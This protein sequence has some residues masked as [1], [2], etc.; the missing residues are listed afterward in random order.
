[1]LRIRLGFN[2]DLDLALYVNADPDPEFDGQNKKI[3][4]YRG[5][6]TVPGT[7]S[8]IK[9]CNLRISLGLRKGHPSYKSSLQPSKANMKIPSL[10]LGFCA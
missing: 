3:K 6:N 10:I 7:I 4:N 9:S 1:M 2:A 5:K 8:L